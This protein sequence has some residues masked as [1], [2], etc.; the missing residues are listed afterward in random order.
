MRIWYFILSRKFSSESF[1]ISHVTNSEADAIAT[2]ERDYPK[3]LRLAQ[4]YATTGTQRN[5]WDRA[6]LAAKALANYSFGRGCQ[7]G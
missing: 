5:A 4:I 6:N 3:S 2:L 7:N 1:R